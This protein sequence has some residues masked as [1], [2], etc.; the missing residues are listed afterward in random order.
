MLTLLASRSSVKIFEYIIISNASNNK[1]ES[2]W[3]TDEK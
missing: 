1:P 3:D 2:G